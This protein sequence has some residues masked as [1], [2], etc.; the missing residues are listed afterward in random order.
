MDGA[1]DAISRI[2]QALADNDKDEGQTAAACARLDAVMKRVP[3]ALL[4]HRQEA[5]KALDREMRRALRADHESKSALGYHR[6]EMRNDSADSCPPWYSSDPGPPD[7]W[8]LIPPI[9]PVAE[10]DVFAD[11]ADG[12]RRVNYSRFTSGGARSAVRESE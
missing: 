3:D 6:P 12:S 9:R 10:S 8:I 7:G 2:D 1:Q 5:L 11:H 4:Y